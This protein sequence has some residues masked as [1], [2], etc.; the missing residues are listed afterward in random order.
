MESYVREALNEG[1]LGWQVTDCLVTMTDCGYASP[2]TSASDF[3]L[4]THLVLMTA[5]E[6]AGTWVC[7]PLADL[8]LEMPASTAQ[9]VLAMLGRLGGRVR[10]Q[11]SAN[12]LTKAH[13]PQCPSLVCARCSISC[14]GCRWG[15]ASSKRAPAAISRSVTT[16]HRDLVPARARSIATRGW[17]RWRNVAAYP[18]AAVGGNNMAEENTESAKL[19]SST[20]PNALVQSVLRESYLQTTEDLRLLRREGPLLQQAETGDPRLPGSL[21]ATRIG[22]QSLAP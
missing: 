17:R 20:D 6:R 3:R 14:P 22:G 11:F 12:G 10:G 13:R 4:L 8:A 5:L 19:S 21:A 18:D 1:L 2:V 7:E 9:A 16:R 15:R